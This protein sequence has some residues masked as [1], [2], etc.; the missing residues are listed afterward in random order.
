M[1][2]SPRLHHRGFQYFMGQ[3]PEIEGFGTNARISSTTVSKPI[4]SNTPERR[5]GQR[6]RRE[7]M[8]ERLFCV[9]KSTDR[10]QSGSARDSFHSALA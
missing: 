3:A 1:W 6:K 2:G 5:E 8:K 10:M 9:L 4:T 7:K